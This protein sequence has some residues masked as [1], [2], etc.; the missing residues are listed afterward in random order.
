MSAIQPQRSLTAFRTSRNGSGS[1]RSSLRRP[2]T[3]T[4]GVRVAA[5]A[6]AGR[7]RV[8]AVLAAVCIVLGGESLAAASSASADA[9]APGWWSG[10]CD[11]NHWNAAAAAR[12]WAGVGAH[13][14]GASYLGVPVCG[15]RPIAD[16]APDVAWAKAGWGEYEWECTELAFR[17]MA[18]IY[19]V[20]AY[21]A[22]GNSVVG[23]YTTA[24]GGNLVKVANGTANQ[25]PKLGD[26]M[27][28][29]SST[30]S[31]GHVAIVS[32]SSVDGNGNGSIGLI[33]QNDTANGSRSL[34]VAN[35]RVAGFGSE[36][37]SGWLHDPAGR[38][39]T[40]DPPP[41]PAPQSLPVGNS[42][43]VRADGT[44]DVYAR[45]ANGDL[46]HKWLTSAGWAPSWNTWET[47]GS[48]LVGDPRAIVRADG[49]VDLYAQGANGSRRSGSL[50]APCLRRRAGRRPQW[51]SPLEVASA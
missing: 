10:A 4:A 18:Q 24:A 21:S 36:V 25:A 38:G 28:F 33:S 14:L 45:G 27:S 48:G 31:F 41:T 19:G 37:P 7:R 43:V 47:L 17:F 16:G 49:T 32:A 42:V 12:G 1:S 39:G 30:N 11:A 46:L 13:P 34:A 9:G 15:P 26:V 5:V 20:S 3:T 8:V 23:N 44:V 2:L 22:N 29:S 35:W 50:T 6:F 51:S 40:S